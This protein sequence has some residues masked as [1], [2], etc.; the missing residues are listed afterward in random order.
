[1]SVAED[2]RRQFDTLF[3]QLLGNR[4]GIPRQTALD[5]QMPKVS[6]TPVK[7]SADLF[8][9]DRGASNATSVPMSDIAKRKDVIEAAKSAI[10]GHDSV[11]STIWNGLTRAFDIVSRPYYAITE[12]AR[13]VQ[14]HLNQGDNPV[15]LLDDALWG[16]GQGL[17]GYKKTSGQDVIDEAAKYNYKDKG[18]L[19]Q[20]AATLQIGR[21][22]G[23]IK[24]KL[25]TEDP[26][27]VA[28][29]IF[30]TASGI[31]LDIGLDPTTYLSGGSKVVYKADKAIN[32][33][34]DIAKGVKAI[35]E[36]AQLAGKE[37]V[38]EG[39]KNTVKRAVEPLLED[40]KVKTF[41]NITG[42]QT[43]YKAAAEKVIDEVVG[44]SDKLLYE[45]RG[46]AQAGKLLG[47][48]DSTWRTLA[49]QGAEAFRSTVDESLK[50]KINRVIK[51]YTIGK[52]SIGKSKN[53]FDRWAQEDELFKNFYDAFITELPNIGD[54][55]KTAEFARANIASNL[56]ETANQITNKLFN[57]FND[58][59]QKIP[60]IRLMGRDIKDL[61]KVGETFSKISSKLKTTDAGT[62]FKTLSYSSQFPGYSSQIA[63]KAKSLGFKNYEDFKNIVLELAKGT[64][65]EERYAI[66]K[67]LL[68]D[69]KLTGELEAKRQAIKALYAE[70]LN[71]EIAK[72]V[73]TI[74]SDLKN[75]SYLHVRGSKAQRDLFFKKR[76]EL[77]KRYGQ[78]AMQHIG[79]DF[80]KSF[81]L[82][83]EPDPF[84]NLN[85]RKMKSS[86]K[87]TRKL[88]AEDLI[89]HYGIKGS[90]ANAPEAVRRDLV[91][92]GDKYIPKDLLKTLSH[93]GQN[94]YLDK[95]IANVLQ[96]YNELSRVD[97]SDAAQWL[98][99]IDFVNGKFKT[100]N[101]IYYPS[102]HIRNFIS[103]MFMGMLDGVKQTDYVKIMK[104]W[105]KA[106]TAMIDIGGETIP[107]AKLRTLFEELAQTGG[108]M[109]T[110]IKNEARHAVTKS[111]RQFSQN[112]E[113]FGRLVHFYHALTEEYPKVLQEMS[114][115]KAL[116]KALKDKALEEAAVTSVF[117]VNKYKFDYGA[118]TKVENSVAKRLIPFYTY[119]RKAIPTLTE[120]MFLS[121]K[122]LSYSNKLFTQLYP[123]MSDSFDP[124]TVPSWMKDMGLIQLTGGSE[125]TVLA[126]NFL[127]TDVLKNNPL[128]ML[129]PIIRAPFEWKM[130]K[131]TFSG[132]KNNGPGDVFK[133]NVRAFGMLDKL[134]IG[135]GT[136]NPLDPNFVDKLKFN[137]DKS[138]TSVLEKIGL[139]TGLPIYK[140][141]TEKQD[142]ALTQRLYEIKG[143]ITKMNDSLNPKGY[144]FMLSNRQDGVSY[145]IRRFDPNTSKNGDILFESKDMRKAIEWLKEHGL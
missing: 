117:R 24:N 98:R 68:G 65:K 99:V 84:H 103:D 135:A 60:T 67:A 32:E 70:I 94:I 134:G 141:S 10:K 138:R 108:F 59:V 109:S 56:E 123:E 57:E 131:D 39:I 81:G 62:L 145:R 107:F 127:P 110:E 1:M 125:P 35:E 102:F 45:T 132:A 5:S 42:M 63:Q 106:E 27:G 88:F 92:V 53:L 51:D 41:S 2:R 55:N 61:E 20:I 36:T 14:Q 31:G 136:L 75:Y 18:L 113:D 4:A 34:E 77:I 38:K 144:N 115:G 16:A 23:T 47:A 91:Q 96:T 83:V 7:G 48:N 6:Y 114:K 71:E 29:K 130:G 79:P 21:P 11:G 137:P 72:G 19:N 100:W 46:G 78:D 126:D 82:K 66:Q 90:I 93:P 128:S 133:H 95:D 129:T 8:T 124:M 12:S 122:Y 13:N 80:A 58:S 140:I 50:P 73:R 105:P 112:R 64:K 85:L 139:G 26:S 15:S 69:Y 142:Q 22:Y 89:M 3:N 104:A 120:S 143:V 25:D 44:M 111:F 86:R 74:G 87:L 121:P 17:G 52:G 40:R 76:D 49:Q 54:I 119:A 9:K 116:T 118:L 37:G 97:G 101:T 28:G 43:G 33:I 30:S